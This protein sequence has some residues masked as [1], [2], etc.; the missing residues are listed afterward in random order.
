MNA[1]CVK[2]VKLKFNFL[3]YR[4]TGWCLQIS[5]FHEDMSS[6]KQN[7]YFDGVELHYILLLAIED[8]QSR[9][10]VVS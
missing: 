1:L 9:H 6:V 10:F 5:L 7:S 8:Y 3:T 2:E 4:A